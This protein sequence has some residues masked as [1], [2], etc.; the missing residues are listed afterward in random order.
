MKARRKWS[1]TPFMV[2]MLVACAS[3]PEDPLTIEEKMLGRGYVMEKPVS[4]VTGWNVRSWSF[5]DNAHFIVYSGAKNQYLVTLKS[6]SFDLSSASNIA[7]TTNFNSLTNQDKVI[8]TSPS[9]VSMRYQIESL[10]PLKKSEN[11]VSQ[12]PAGSI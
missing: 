5:V 3:A 1:L 2:F 10:H 4:R 6:P 11:K 12:P 8:V 9:G 7:F